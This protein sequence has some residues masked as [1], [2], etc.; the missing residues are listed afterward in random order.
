MSTPQADA[1]MSRAPG[2][3][4]LAPAVRLAGM[5]CEA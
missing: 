4:D 3:A 2:W 1:C 5:V